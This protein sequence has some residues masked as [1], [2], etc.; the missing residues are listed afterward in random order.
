M[1]GKHSCSVLKNRDFQ[2]KIYTKKYHTLPTTKDII[3][4]IYSVS[5]ILLFPL[6]LL[7]K[8]LNAQV[9]NSSN[10]RKVNSKRNMHL[11]AQY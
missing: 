7:H 4:S 5:C 9:Q 2:T 6:T 1:V 8:N 3:F 11:G 10:I